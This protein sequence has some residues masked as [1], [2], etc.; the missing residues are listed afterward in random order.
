MK[1]SV[2]WYLGLAFRTRQPDGVLL[3]AHAGQ[4]TTLLCQVGPQPQPQHSAPALLPS[5]P[6]EQADP[7]LRV[8]S[9]P[10]R[11][12]LWGEVFSRAGFPPPCSKLR[13]RVGWRQPELARALLTAAV[14]DSLSAAGWGPA[15]LHG[16]QG[17]RA[18]HQPSPGPAAGQRWEM[19]R[20][21]A[22][23][24]GCPQWARLALRHHPH[25]GLWALSGKCCLRP[26][27]QDRSH[28]GCLA[29][30]GRA[31][32]LCPQKGLGQERDRAGA[33]LMLTLLLVL[34]Q[35]TVVVGNELHG[36]KV[37]HLHVGGV[38]G[39]GEV[40]NGLR[41]CIQVSPLL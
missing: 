14:A 33:G 12:W 1:I 11:G 37:K 22:G 29:Y 23:A 41:G 31:G 10:S 13:R 39:S 35:D 25:P 36:L 9:N 32:P 16:E 3:Q 20:P 18:Q 15:L 24:A 38:L 6:G 40:Q 17:V 4:Y 28:G 21:P 30:A 2:P 26:W 7:A 5:A 19:A 8:D 34:L 27:H